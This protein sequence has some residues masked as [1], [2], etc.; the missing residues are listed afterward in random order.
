MIAAIDVRKSTGRGPYFDLRSV[1]FVPQLVSW[2][3]E[4]GELTSVDGPKGFA[5]WEEAGRFLRT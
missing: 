2:D 3:P 4:P 1:L 5:T